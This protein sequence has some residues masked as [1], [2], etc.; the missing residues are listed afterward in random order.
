MPVEIT[1]NG[2][3]G[4]QMPRMP[5]GLMKMMGGLISFMISRRGGKL[6]TLVTIGSKTGRTHEVE[7]GWFPDRENTWLIVASAAGAAKHPAWYFNLA[8][9]PDKV[10]IVVDGRKVKVHPESL[11]G[12]EYEQKF[13]E[14][15]AAMPN[16][17]EYRTKTDRVIPVIRLVAEPEGKS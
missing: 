7:L 15:A 17:G 6:L 3:Y 8:R 10:W 9:N 12:D 2:T 5:R 11:K 16:Y 1:P 13:K 14:I 4:A